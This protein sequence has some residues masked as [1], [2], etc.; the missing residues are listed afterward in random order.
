MVFII[1]FLFLKTNSL[2]KKKKKKKGPLLV[3]SCSLF[4]KNELSQEYHEP[5]ILFHDPEDQYDFTEGGVVKVYQPW[6]FFIYIF[7]E[8]KNNFLIYNLIGLNSETKIIV[9][10]YFVHYFKFNL[11]MLEVT[12]Q[13]NQ[14]HFHFSRHLVNF[15]FFCFFNNLILKK[16]KKKEKQR[17]Q[18]N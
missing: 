13:R 4:Q 17:V 8:K 12:H 14:I 11:Q 9:S 10:H 18:K 3:T 1:F 7:I 2:T 6:F 5:E 15:L 16:K